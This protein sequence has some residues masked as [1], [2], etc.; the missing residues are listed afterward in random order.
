MRIQIF[1]FGI[2]V[3]HLFGCGFL[4][5]PYFGHHF[6]SF[7]APQYA[8]VGARQDACQSSKSDILEDI[9]FYYFWFHV[10]GIFCDIF[11]VLKSI[12]VIHF[13]SRCHGRR[14]PYRGLKWIN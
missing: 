6:S 4:H 11:T 5:W 14:G 12:F 7:K 10:C 2:L 3:G 1:F 8:T 13:E 9:V